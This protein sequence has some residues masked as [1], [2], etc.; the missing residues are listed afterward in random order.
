MTDRESENIVIATALAFLLGILLAVLMSCMHTP[1]VSTCVEG[2]VVV[3][4]SIDYVCADG[5]LY[6]LDNSP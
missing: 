2:D 4:N 6:R 5:K 1:R 3:I